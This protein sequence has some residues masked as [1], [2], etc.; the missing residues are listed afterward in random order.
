[1]GFGPDTPPK[2]S[3]IWSGLQ[4]RDRLSGNRESGATRA[5]TD[6][7]RGQVLIDQSPGTES[8]PTRGDTTWSLPR[9]VPAAVVARVPAAIT[10]RK[11]SLYLLLVQLGERLCAASIRLPRSP[12][13]GLV[14]T[15][16]FCSRQ[17]P[18]FRG[19][20]SPTRCVG[21]NTGPIPRNLGPEPCASYRVSSYA[22]PGCGSETF[23][24]R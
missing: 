23:E 10:L 14:V 3:R 5:G 24:R 7:P 18:P 15:S 20:E 2:P 9:S 11:S 17:L 22:G 4:M 19:S 12:F 6:L 1:M 8:N 13:S 21:D 16:I